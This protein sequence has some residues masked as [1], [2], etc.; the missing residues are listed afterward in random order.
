MKSGLSFT[1][2]KTK[3][4]I[5]NLYYI[6]IYYLQTTLSLPDIIFSYN[7]ISYLFICFSLPLNSMTSFQQ[8]IFDF[9]P[10]T[11]EQDLSQQIILCMDHS[12]LASNHF[13]GEFLLICFLLKLSQTQIKN[14]MNNQSIII[15]LTNHNRNHYETIFRKHSIDLKQLEND[16]KIVFV[17]IYATNDDKQMII[18]STS[19]K[20]GD[21]EMNCLHFTWDELVSWQKEGMNWPHPTIPS[22]HN[23]IIVMI[24]DLE[25]LEMLSPTFL[26]ARMFVHELLQCLENEEKVCYF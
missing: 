10:W 5:N 6:I 15:F 20:K 18:S 13:S 7:I 8:K 9:A 2:K 3:V 23:K 25:M 17:Y 16:G 4:I 12:S 21:K 19:E 1:I 22:K 14:A 11:I 26:Q 24:D